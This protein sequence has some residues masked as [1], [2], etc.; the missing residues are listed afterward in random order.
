MLAEELAWPDGDGPI[1]GGPI[2]ED[3]DPNLDPR[4]VVQEV[5]LGDKAIAED[6]DPRTDEVVQLVEKSGKRALRHM[7]YWVLGGALLLLIAILVLSYLSPEEFSP[8]AREVLTI[9]TFTVGTVLGHYFTK[10]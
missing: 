2:Y 8:V 6:E 1:D 9:T 3:I 4:P 7:A 10:K 5:D